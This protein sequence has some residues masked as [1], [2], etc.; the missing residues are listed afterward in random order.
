MPDSFALTLGDLVALH[1][2]WSFFC[3]QTVPRK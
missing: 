2:F 3:T 1:L